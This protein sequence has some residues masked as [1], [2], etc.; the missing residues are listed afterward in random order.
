MRVWAYA[1]IAATIAAMLI[2]VYLTGRWDAGAKNERDGL[3]DTIEAGE[4]FNE[5]AANP[6]NVGWRERL[7]PSGSD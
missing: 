3:R 4:K 6:D 1:L 5:G 2:A 7:F